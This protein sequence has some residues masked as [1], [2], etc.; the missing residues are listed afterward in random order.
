MRRHEFDPLSFVFG[1][2][3]AAIGIAFLTGHVDLTDLRL[4][5]VWPIPIMVLGLLMLVSARRREQS[6]RTGH[7]DTNRSDERTDAGPATE[8]TD[9]ARA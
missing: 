8:E 5:W 3:I 9:E 1:A 6:P 4:T 2:V 7:A